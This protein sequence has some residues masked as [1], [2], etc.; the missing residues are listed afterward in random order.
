M[1]FPLRGSPGRFRCG[2][3]TGYLPG[4]TLGRCDAGMAL[5]EGKWMISF[6]LKSV[7]DRRGTSTTSNS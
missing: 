5:L 7:G 1:P 3:G 2:R 4:E 6:K